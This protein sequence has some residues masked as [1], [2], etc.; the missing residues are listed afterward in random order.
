[1]NENE[2]IKEEIRQLKQLVTQTKKPYQILANILAPPI[3]FHEWIKTF[4]VSKTHL[5][6]I[7][8]FD[9]MEG[10]KSCLRDR[11]HT[12]GISNIPIRT[13]PERRHVLYMYDVDETNP[14]HKKWSVCDT[15][16]MMTIIDQI[17]LKF[18][19]AFCEWDEENHQR[20]QSTQE[21]K[22]K[23]S[24][25]MLKVEGK[26]FRKYKDKYRNELRNWLSEQVLQPNGSR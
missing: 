13:P 3:V 6:R 21:D 16:D 19:I 11:I 18:D 15:D 7:F 10:L 20:M 24:L 23:Y 22:D 5:E 25:Y 1:M 17:T 2:K 4:H 8:T 12:E 26:D 14:N 9:I